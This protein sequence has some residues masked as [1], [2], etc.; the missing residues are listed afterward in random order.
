MRG[1][2]AMWQSCVVVG[3]AAM[4]PAGTGFAQAQGGEQSRQP[5]TVAEESKYTKT[6]TS[7]QVEGFLRDIDAAS[8]RA[9]LGSIGSSTRGKD[10]PLLVV[11]DPPVTSAQEARESDRLVVLLFGNIHAGEVAG[12][13]ALLALARELAVGERS[14]LLDD[15]VVCFVP[16][17]NPDGNDEMAAGNRPGQVGPDEMGRR[18]NGQGL[19]LNRDWIKME[20]PET[21][22]LVRFMREWDPAVVVDT[23]TTNGSHHRYVITYA[24]PK[25]PASDPRLVE[26]V[27]D[28][29]LPEVDQRFEASSDYDAFWYGNFAER[30]T[31]WTTYPSWP[32][33]G[34]SYRGLANRVSIL[35][36]AYAYASYED[37]IRGTIEFCRAVLE[38][39][40]AQ[41]HSI[42]RAVRDAKRFQSS[43]QSREISLR[44]RA[45]VIDGTF[46]VLGYQEYDD[47]GERVEVTDEHRTYDVQ[48]MNDF[49]PTVTVERPWGYL[50]PADL[51]HVAEHLQRHGVEVQEVREQIDLDGVAYRLDVVQQAG[52]AFQG[53]HMLD[54]PEVTPQPRTVRVEPGWFLVE[55]SQELGNLAAYMLE[56]QATDSLASWN[57]LEGH[58]EEGGQYPIVRLESDAPILTRS[59]RPLDDERQPPR[60]ITS[61][62]VIERR[63]APRLSGQP[64]ARYTWLDDDRL[65]KTMPRGAGRHV[66]DAA[67]GRVVGQPPVRDWEPVAD[68]IARLPTIDRNRARQLA[69]SAFDEERDAPLVF[70]H[71]DDLYFVS[72]DG[73]QAARLTATPQREEVWQLSP[74]DQF[75]AYV[76]DNDLWVV[77]LLTQT[78]RALTTGG[79]EVLRHGKASWLYFE[80]L[81]GRNWRAFWWSPDSQN[82][83]FLITD[84]SNVPEYTIVDLQRRE[85]KIEVERYARPG[86]PNPHVELGFVSRDGGDIRLADLSAYDDGLYLISHVGWTPDGDRC[87]VHVQDRIQTQL[88]VLHASPRGGEPT[89]LLRDSTEAWINSPKDFMY[90]E[91]R[92]FLMFS[93]RDGFKH[94][95][96]YHDNGD[97]IRQVTQGQWECRRVL[98]IDEDRGIIFFT[99]TGASPIGNDLFTIRLDGTGL[100]RLTP[101]PGS[102]SV[103]LNPSGTMFIDAW[104]SLN[105]PGRVALR[106]SKDGSLIR[107]L[108]TNPVYELADY[109]LA[110]LE[111]V[112]IPS[113]REGVEL[114]AI[115]HYPPGFDA[116]RQ[117]PVW[118]MTYAGPGAPT[119]RDSW[120]GARMWE[121]LLC[122]AGIVVLRVD[123]YAASGK[124]A[125]SAW[126]SYLNLG[127]GELRDLEDAVQWAIDQGWADAERV[128]ISGHSFGGYITAYAMT[129]S[130]MFSAGIAG[131]PVTD[132]RDYDTIYTERYMSTPQANPEGYKRTSAVEGAANL[133]G[134]LLIAHGEIDDNVHL[135]NTI[136]LVGALQRAGKLF[137]MAIY[138]GSRHGIWSSQYRVLQWDFIKRTMA[139]D[140]PMEF[141]GKDAVEPGDD[142]PGQRSLSE[143]SVGP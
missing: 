3:L 17:Y 121:Q 48:L 52:R 33:Y 40:A 84:S 131:A 1:M 143:T 19:D 118:V 85:Q 99:G 102:H 81:F 13:E 62:M 65:I 101:E 110:R 22:A 93:E 109:D 68:V 107:W 24:G 53:H 72:A 4:W 108:D 15:L 92:S 45:I 11:A 122:S 29:F 138:P 94:L 12:K 18:P 90:L 58:I 35:S 67:T 71:E 86:E 7:A 75:V 5:Q 76:S 115:V 141:A 56:P 51:D 44:E 47:Q 78:P 135:H 50:I 36:E 98:K 142:S 6:S 89:L 42:E 34:A 104:S 116:S 27:R 91:D 134:R 113:R 49:E 57:F 26:Y 30:H 130:T 60:R 88:D 41:R 61:E 14:A 31:Q 128:G 137:E 77:D 73:S 124:G 96:H 97:L 87:V 8:D 80:E 32:R 16:N 69:R 21:R 82:I 133:H 37:R 100:T 139:V 123:P 120:Q 111:H 46:K 136:L 9:W 126:T 106:S 20:A 66:V 129:H 125:Q 64:G 95:Y 79:S 114:E 2:R 140:E 55:A 70:E 25:H 43:S 54:I 39:A 132:W 59:A 117:H 74:D 23:H 127:V 38:E 119:V 10:L 83:A 63:G 112:H 105:E 103:T 28:Q